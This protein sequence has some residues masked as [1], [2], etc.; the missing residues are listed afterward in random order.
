MILDGR[1]FSTI[2]QG[3]VVEVAFADEKELKE[4]NRML[5]PDSTVLRSMVQ[6]M[7]TEKIKMNIKFGPVET[8]K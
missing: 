1:F 3:V 4:W 7:D 6:G 8:P 5:Y 2:T